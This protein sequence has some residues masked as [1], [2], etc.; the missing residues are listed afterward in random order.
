MQVTPRATAPADPHA[1]IVDALPSLLVGVDWQQRAR[2]RHARACSSGRR[3][4]RSCSGSGGSRRRRA[5]SSRRAS[6]TGRRC[7]AATTRR[8]SRSSRSNTPTA[9]A[10]ATS[11]RWRSSRGEPADADAEAARRRACSRGSPAR[12]KARS[13]TASTTMTRAIGCSGSSPAAEELATRRGAC[14]DSWCR[15]RRPSVRSPAAAHRWSAS[16]RRPE[17]QRRVRGRPLRAEAVPADRTGAESGIRDRPVPDRT[18]VRPHAGARR[19]ARLP[20]RRPRARHAGRRAGGGEASGLGM[21][22]HA[23]TT[24]AATTSG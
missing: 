23:S 3:C 6:P 2:R 14:R 4:G 20:A 5:R 9:G 8:S 12:A 22:L 10:R 15:S 24:C 16:E 11:C 7:A 18:W 17:Q 19:R 1:A 13:S 21:G